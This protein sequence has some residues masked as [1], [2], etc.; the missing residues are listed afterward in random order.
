MRYSLRDCRNS[1][2]ESQVEEES[3][4]FAFVF[5]VV[6]KERGN[7]VEEEEGFCCERQREGIACGCVSRERSGVSTM[8]VVEIASGE[9]DLESGGRDGKRDERKKESVE[10]RDGTGSGMGLKGEA[11]ERARC[12]EC[13]Q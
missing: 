3:G 12:G 7:R 6:E 4:V 8:I 11:L 10:E 1:R 13:G 9:S 5:V 2:R